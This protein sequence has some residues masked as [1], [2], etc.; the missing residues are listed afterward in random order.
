MEDLKIMRAFSSTQPSYI[1]YSLEMG[2]T[3]GTKG[4]GPLKTVIFSRFTLI[5]TDFLLAINCKDA[6]WNTSRIVG[7]RAR[8]ICSCIS[9]S[10]LVRAT[11]LL[12]LTTQQMWIPKSKCLLQCLR[13]NSWRTWSELFT[14]ILAGDRK[15]HQLGTIRHPYSCNRSPSAFIT[16]VKIRKDKYG[17]R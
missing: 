12:E 7:E 14:M 5:N 16:S 10:L 6:D 11:V 3:E 9:T 4:N 17:Q 1:F 13:K 15:G 2:E 8:T